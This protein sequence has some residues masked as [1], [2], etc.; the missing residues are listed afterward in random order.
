VAQIVEYWLAFLNSM[1]FTKQKLY[2]FY[3]RSSPLNLIILCKCAGKILIMTEGVPNQQAQKLRGALR[4][5]EPEA[6]W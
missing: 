5:P 6:E 1:D 4:I 2:Q 3:Q